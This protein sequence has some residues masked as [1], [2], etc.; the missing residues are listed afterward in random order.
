MGAC[1]IASVTRKEKALYFPFVLPGRK[2][3]LPRRRLRRRVGK[4]GIWFELAESTPPP[5]THSHTHIHTR[6]GPSSPGK[7][8]GP[9]SDSRPAP[10]AA[11]TLTRGGP[12]RRAAHP[13][14]ARGWWGAVLCPRTEGAPGRGRGYRRPIALHRWERVIKSLTGRSR[15]EARP[16]AFGRAPRAATGRARKRPHPA[17][18]RRGR[19]PSL[20]L[21]VSRGGGRT[22]R[23]RASRG[24]RVWGGRRV[25]SLGRSLPGGSSPLSARR[26]DT[27]R[28]VLRRVYQGECARLCHYARAIG[29]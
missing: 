22:G 23:G 20:G 24:G 3:K 18:R 14:R 8:A 12:A 17:D 15:L 6:P 29:F 13:G 9:R 11:R 10:P 25:C 19:P 7:P 2:R 26:G 16:G 1:Q 27:G 21:R 28:R 4:R 5:D